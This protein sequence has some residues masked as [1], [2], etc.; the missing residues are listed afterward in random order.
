MGPAAGPGLGPG[1]CWASDFLP[2]AA[3][4]AQE[5]EVYK[6]AGRRPEEP[7]QAQPEALQLAI[8]HAT[9]VFGTDFDVVVEVGAPLRRN[10]GRRRGR[11]V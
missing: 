4:S 11:R 8:L 5:R 9:A 7:G 10:A 1:S 2:V 6:K 3:G